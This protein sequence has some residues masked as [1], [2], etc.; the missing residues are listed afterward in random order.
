MKI[1]TLL[2]LLLIFATTVA[3]AQEYEQAVG[4]RAGYSGGISYRKFF[5]AWYGGEVIAQYNRN[6][7][8]VAGLAEWQT[9]PFKVDRLC[10]FSGGGIYAGNWDGQFAF[11]ITAVAG[12]EYVLRDL[13]LAVSF[14]YKPMLNL[15]KVL[16]LDPFDFAFSLRYTF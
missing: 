10:L 15:G 9:A 6:G 1:K 13:P 11:G 14:D 8:Q 2:F 12:I 7:F 4:I 3:Y 5:N 16:A